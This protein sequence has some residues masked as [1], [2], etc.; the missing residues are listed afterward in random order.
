MDFD[1]RTKPQREGTEYYPISL[2][3]QEDMVKFLYNEFKSFE[4]QVTPV[5]WEIGL[6][7]SPEELLSYTFENGILHL[8]GNPAIIMFRTDD[9]P[10]YRLPNGGISSHRHWPW[11]RSPMWAARKTDIVIP[12]KIQSDVAAAMQQYFANRLGAPIPNPSKERREGLLKWALKHPAAAKILIQ[13]EAPIDLDEYLSTG[14]TDSSE[15]GSD[16][17]LSETDPQKGEASE[18]ATPT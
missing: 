18:A 6:V 8:E 3:V 15:L 5:D 1:V 4:E 7:F 2:T 16:P 12:E 10:P 17:V 9:T 13:D 11:Y 14:N